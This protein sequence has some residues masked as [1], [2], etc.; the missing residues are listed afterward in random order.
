M[1]ASFLPTHNGKLKPRRTYHARHRVAARVMY[2]AAMAILGIVL[3]VS[4]TR[5]APMTPPSE[6]SVRQLLHGRKILVAANYFDNMDIL[7]AHTKQMASFL[8]MLKAAG[9]E[10][11]VSVYE[12]GSSDDTPAYLRQWGERLEAMNVPN[13]INIDTAPGWK[14]AYGAYLKAHPENSESF[15]MF[16]IRFMAQVRNA[17]L[18]P[19]EEQPFDD[20]VFFND[21]LFEATDIL[22][23]LMTENLNYDAVCAM[24]FN[25][26]TLYDT[27][28]ARDV[29]GQAMSSFYPF[30]ADM[31]SIS[32]V[33][34]GK[35]FPV[36]SC[37]NGVVAMK[38]APF[39]HDKVRF[40]T[41]GTNEPRMISRRTPMKKAIYSDS[42]PASECG[43]I[44]EDFAKFGYTNVY[45]HPSVHVT[46]CHLDQMLHGVFG[47]ALNLLSWL[48]LT[49]RPHKRIPHQSRVADCGYDRPMTVETWVYVVLALL[50]VVLLRPRAKTDKS[51]PK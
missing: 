11:Y 6:E 23:L 49:V 36:S 26:V 13:H 38:A 10:P 51:P 48:F 1:A 4:A 16:R 12:N 30:T 40:R 47:G 50:F 25:H 31:E 44:F 8:T 22:H 28:V 43:L 46:Y 27:W 21:V 9:A 5:E 15:T 17:A 2:I 35:P 39:V 29:N 41:W 34:Q 14:A 42:C 20:I 24:D 32:L 18:K 19:L 7:D 37:W 45:M 33:L 3:F